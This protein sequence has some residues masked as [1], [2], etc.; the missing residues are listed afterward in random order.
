MSDSASRP[1]NFAN[2]PVLTEVLFEP[3]QSPVRKAPLDLPAAHHGGS[4]GLSQ[5]QIEE[6]LKDFQRD[7]GATIEKECRAALQ[8]HLT[9]Q[10]QPLARALAQEVSQAL[11]G[12]LRTWL[13]HRVSK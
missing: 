5:T 3:A 9:A 8:T 6:L 10:I 11:E 4:E 13:S 12:K 2:I 1:P 7:W